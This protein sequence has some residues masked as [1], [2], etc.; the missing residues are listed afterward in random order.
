MIDLLKKKT[1]IF[2]IVGIVLIILV[3]T[4]IITRNKMQNNKSASINTKNKPIQ[5]S[6]NNTANTSSSPIVENND[7]ST[8]SSVSKQSNATNTSSSVATPSN[9]TSTNSSV[10]EQKST[11]SAFN[12]QDYFGE[13]TIKKSLGTAPVSAMSKDQI[14][15]YIGKKITLSESQF[16]DLDGSVV[17]NP[18]YKQKIVSDNDFF[19]DNRRKLSYFQISSNYINEIQIYNNG[20]IYSNIFIIDKDNIMYS[21]DGVFFQLQK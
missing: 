13:W 11:T 12:Y 19:N 1:A 4:F 15:G 10:T 18:T 5:N 2:V 16:I 21:A 8:N 7:T 20:G 6:V 3:G 14:A 17:K 9:T